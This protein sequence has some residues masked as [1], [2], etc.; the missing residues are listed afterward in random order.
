MKVIS[1]KEK[2]G[3]SQDTM[4]CFLLWPIMGDAGSVRV[5]LEGFT[6]NGWYSRMGCAWWTILLRISAT[7]LLSRSCKDNRHTEVRGQRYE[8]KQANK[9]TKQYLFFHLPLRLKLLCKILLLLHK[10]VKL[11][12]KN[13]GKTKE[14]KNVSQKKKKKKKREL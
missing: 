10:P 4:L 8:P 1:K 11:F 13:Q 3:V 9:Q 14:E 5:L 2:K 12:H 7:S 6:T